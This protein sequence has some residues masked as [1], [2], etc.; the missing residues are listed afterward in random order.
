MDKIHNA[1]HQLY[2]AYYDEIKKA[3][4]P[5]KSLDIQLM[6]RYIDADNE[7][8]IIRVKQVDLDDDGAL[9]YVMD[10]FNGD[11]YA[12]DVHFSDDVC[13]INERSESLDNSIVQSIFDIDLIEA[14][15][16]EVVYYAIPRQ[17]EALYLLVS[18]LG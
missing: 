17:N 11:D 12:S 1:L 8:D 10:T 3:I 7:Q 13:F 4:E 6:F 15:Y 2:Y 9:S 18:E 5:Y 16:N 14:I